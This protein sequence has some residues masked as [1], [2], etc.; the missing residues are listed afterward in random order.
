MNG[1]FPI[2]RRIRRPLLPPESLPT[3]PVNPLP[4]L[5]ED[6]GAETKPPTAKA[7]NAKAAEDK[8]SGPTE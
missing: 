2:I 8:S 3:A 1:L 6:K 4:S 5:A 7:K